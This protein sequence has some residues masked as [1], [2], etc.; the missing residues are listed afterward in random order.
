M[1]HISVSA[2]LC[3]VSWRTSRFS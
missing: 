1:T 2:A 3:Y